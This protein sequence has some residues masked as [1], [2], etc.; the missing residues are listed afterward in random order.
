MRAAW[1][2]RLSSNVPIR[3]RSARSRSRSTSATERRV[4]LREAL[5]LGEQHAVL[6]DHRLAVP[7]EVGGRL[8]LARRGVDVRR[9]AARR[10]RP[11]QQARGLGPP[12]RDR[13]AGEVGQHG[14]PGQRRLGARRHRH[15][16][17]LADLD[18]QHEARARP[19]R[20][21]A[22]RARTA[23]RRPPT[24]IVPRSVVAR[25][26][27]AA[28]VEL[29]VGRQVRLRRDAQQPPAV[30]DGGDVVDPVPVRGPAARRRAPAAGRPSRST[31]S[32]SARLGRV[33]QGVLQQDVLDRVARSASARG[34]S[35]SPTPSSAH[36]RA[37]AQHGRG[38]RRGV[39]D[40][41]AQR[42]RRRPGGSRAD[43]AERN[44]ST[45]PQSARNPDPSNL[46]HC[47]HA[48]VREASDRVWSR[49][50]CAAVALL[51]AC[52]RS[53]L[54]RPHRRAAPRRGAAIRPPPAAARGSTRRSSRGARAAVRRHRGD[55]R[56]SPPTRYHC[57]RLEVPLDYAKPDGPTAEL[58]VLRLKATGD[59]DRLAGVQPRWP[60]RVRA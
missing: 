60:R 20:R 23:P 9:E 54:H 45:R 36:S 13:A 4:A 38:V 24:R 8:A 40:R 32:A 3:S 21:T 18:V 17:V 48:G 42:A 5:R 51:V 33:E 47:W 14:R 2:R 59:R 30:H 31:T 50:C 57:A 56:R 49:C 27:L 34:R 26:D 19:R 37:D 22:G 35:P 58:G 1:W 41:G 25:R 29:P 55:A 43:T 6:P 7:G 52:S 28:L 44:P 46:R 53:R 39:G 15:P 16:H 12:D 11:R 10:R